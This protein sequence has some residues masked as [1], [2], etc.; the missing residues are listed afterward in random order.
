[1]QN[2]PFTQ[3]LAQHFGC[4]P[5]FVRQITR[6]LREANLLTTGARGVNAPHMTAQDAA[7][8][9]LAILAGATPTTAAEEVRQWGSFQIESITRPQNDFRPG[10]FREIGPD[11]EST[12]L[13]ALTD[14]FDLYGDPKTLNEHAWK[15]NGQTMEPCLSITLSERPRGVT[16]IEGSAQINFADIQAR[17]MISTA[18]AAVR[19][20]MER[21]QEAIST[22]DEASMVKAEFDIS[23]ARKDLNQAN[24]KFLSKKSGVRVT[25]TLTQEEIIP[26][27]LAL[28]SGPGTG[29][30]M[31]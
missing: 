4:D 1:M 20:G 12:L 2:G 22:Y 11:G 18:S 13:E 6:A 14:V 7:R 29:G 27:A 9:A 23:E 8:V 31:E 28:Y 15:M 21:F 3:T 5:S 26:V 17:E 25:R 19:S 30:P 10:P 16:M 24:A